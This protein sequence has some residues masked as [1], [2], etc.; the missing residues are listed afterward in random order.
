MKLYFVKVGGV[1]T[2]FN[3]I[4]RCNLYAQCDPDEGSDVA[5]DEDNCDQEYKNKGLVP[6]KATFRCQ[7]PHYNQ[8]SVKANLSRGVVYIHECSKITTQSAGMGRTR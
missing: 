8:D 5:K 2:C 4:N 6:R 7:F 1:E 3:K